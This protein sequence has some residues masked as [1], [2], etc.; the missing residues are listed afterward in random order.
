MS[1]KIIAIRPKKDCN[2]K[3]LKN[4]DIGT[5]YTFYKDYKITESLDFKSI[6]IQ[7]EP[8]IPENLYD[9]EHTKISISAIVGKN[10]SGKSSL[11]ELLYIVV[12]NLS[13]QEG[14]IA[15]A[16][17]TPERIF[18]FTNFDFSKLEANAL[19]Y[20]LAKPKKKYIENIDED[21]DALLNLR[22]EI[23]KDL[24]N[25]PSKVDLSRHQQLKNYD[26]IKNT[27]G[28]ELWHERSI[29][30]IDHQI[31]T[32]NNIKFDLERSYKFKQQ[33]TEDK[34]DPVKKINAQIIFETDGE[35]FLIE[36]EDTTVKIFPFKSTIKK[37]KSNY[38]IK[39]DEQT[40][41]I[42]NNL[43]TSKKLFYNI[44]NNYSLYGL[45]SLDVGDWITR[46]FHKNDGYQTPIVMN[47]MRT[48][49]KIDINIE[50][51]L[52]KS[53]LLSNILKKVEDKMNLLDS[54]RSLV[55]NKIADT[56]ILTFNE[57]KFKNHRGKVELRYLKYQNSLLHK[58]LNAFKN[59]DQEET[60]ESEITLRFNNISKIEKFTIEYIFRKID[61]IARTY[62]I[63][64]RK[65]GEKFNYDYPFL[66]DELLFVLK[67]DF[68]H[69]TFKLRQ[70]INFLNYD[71]ESI[72]KT[73][74]NLNISVD[75]LSDEIAKN[76]EEL[77]HKDATN[78]K[79]VHSP[80]D[81]DFFYISHV[82]FELIN[83][84][85]PSFY[86]MDINFSNGTG[87]FN[88]LS[89]GEKQHIY[90]IS[91][92]IYH[93]YN[94]KSISAREPAKYDNFNLIFD[95]IELYFHPDFQ[96]SYIDDLLS[97]I[98]KMQ[99]VFNGINIIFV[100]HSPFI[101]SDIPPSN[102]LFLNDGKPDEKTNFKTF[103]ANIHDLLADSFFM[104]NGYMGKFAHSK[105]DKTIKWLYEKYS[106]KNDFINK[107]PNKKYSLIIDDTERKSHKQIIDMIDE[108][109]LK[110]KLLDMY[111]D[112]FT[113]E[114]KKEREIREVIENANRLG[115]TIINPNL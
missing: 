39:I 16:E 72:D 33:S 76:L 32:F 111:N 114:G 17:A 94:L 12:Y 75:T 109:I 19:S 21:L 18:E 4:L 69:V 34:I 9:Q 15:E 98:G 115:L 26:I 92:I 45:N 29:E 35:L 101:L 38:S 31:K 89:S 104:P 71:Y 20:N 6:G 7:Y 48:E 49:G 14:F 90:S 105:I 77:I 5:F 2:K 11:V 93:L 112:L 81:G 107:Y 85:P 55:N 46:L 8:S 63:K 95:E 58:I 23:M 3:F 47:P 82:K 86:K 62:K 42:F 40:K 108:P 44:V 73:K 106:L 65:F 36:A 103:G 70:A 102:I 74:D 57:D 52:S 60:N 99:N 64:G 84:L 27:F 68:S 53:R 87:S 80:K 88:D 10:G 56:I 51:Y 13:V 110:S 41:N 66:L 37:D 43:K 67:D 96:K 54:L 28:E 97:S 25:A 22:L 59:I 79:F 24:E 30:N 113:A 83:F 100:T 50:H 1:F 61:K 78:A 91:S